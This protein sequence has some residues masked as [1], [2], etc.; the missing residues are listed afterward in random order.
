MAC[1]LDVLVT[2]RGTVEGIVTPEDPVEGSGIP[3]DPG[4]R[5]P[6]EIDS[7]VE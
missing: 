2:E 5:V 3:R 7:A 4:P 6:A 1:P